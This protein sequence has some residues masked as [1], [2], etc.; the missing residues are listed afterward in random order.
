LRQFTDGFKLYLSSSQFADVKDRIAILLNQAD[1]LY[2]KLLEHLSSLA[3]TKSQEEKYIDII[4]QYRETF[5]QL[6][7]GYTANEDMLI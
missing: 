1:A 3:L 4:G 6:K 7:I 5:R 2:E